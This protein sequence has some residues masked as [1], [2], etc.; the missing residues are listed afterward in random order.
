MLSFCPR[1]NKFNKHAKF[2]LIEI[3]KNTNKAKESLQKL[4]KRRGHFWIRTLAILSPRG[5]NHE[6]NPEGLYPANAL[7]KFKF[8]YFLK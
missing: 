5:L 3:I 1:Q 8:A 6:L 7:F 2:T 4:L